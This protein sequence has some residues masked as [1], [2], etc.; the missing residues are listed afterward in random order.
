VVLKFTVEIKTIMPQL[1]KKR[2]YQT[3][4]V[5]AAS[6]LGLIKKNTRVYINWR[7]TAKTT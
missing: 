1:H 3:Y 5:G 2:N 7:V 6:E 4:S